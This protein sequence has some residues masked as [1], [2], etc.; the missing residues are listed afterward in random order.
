VVQGNV[1]TVNRRG[2][3]ALGALVWIGCGGRSSLDGPE[4]IRILPDGA[5]LVGEGEGAGRSGVD[6]ATNAAGSS[7]AEAARVDGAGT[8]DGASSDAAMGGAM[9]PDAGIRDAATVSDGAAARD[10]AVSADGA[11]G[12]DGA[13]GDAGSRTIACGATA[14]DA[15]REECCAQ[16][17]GSSCTAIGACTGGIPLSCSSGASCATGDVCCLALG[18]AGPT[19]TCAA[20][21]GAVGAGAQLCASN[22]ECAPREQ[23][24][25]ALAGLSICQPAAAGG[26]V[27]PG[28]P[29][30]PGH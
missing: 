30:A 10:S 23:C 19:S 11:I 14:C 1:M 22:S 16:G 15:T 28:A 20:N 3:L 26:G 2:A 12:P 24:R 5:I 27:G 13:P 6:A 4:I 9:R 8:R 21:C 17:G 25:A 29:G 18:R 7:D